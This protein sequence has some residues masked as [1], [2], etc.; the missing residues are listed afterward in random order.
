MMELLKPMERIGFFMGCTAIRCSQ[1][2]VWQDPWFNRLWR[3]ECN[4]VEHAE[5]DC[6]S[7]V[8]GVGKSEDFVNTWRVGTEARFDARLTNR[9]GSAVI[10]AD[11]GGIPANNKLQ[12]R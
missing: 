4:A 6:L 2:N 10:I 9:H 11:P 5:S 3:E 1:R 12:M 7:T 8:D